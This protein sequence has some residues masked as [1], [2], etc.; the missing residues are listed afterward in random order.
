M[1][2]RTEGG[3]KTSERGRGYPHKASPAAVEKYLHGIQFHT[4]TDISKEVEKVD[5]GE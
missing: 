5:R 3:R 2:G 1:G 4:L